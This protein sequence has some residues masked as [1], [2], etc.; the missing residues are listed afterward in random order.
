M[1]L[2]INEAKLVFKNSAL[3]V[4]ATGRPGYA[5]EL[6]VERRI[7]DKLGGESWVDPT[8]ADLGSGASLGQIN[9]VAQAFAALAKEVAEQE[10]LLELIEGDARALGW[11]GRNDAPGLRKFLRELKEERERPR[12]A[13]PR[14][15]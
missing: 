10:K 7:E 4:V 9:L 15:S 14:A 3:R 13:Q 1:N 11:D 8:D 6:T 2:G 12:P 5:V